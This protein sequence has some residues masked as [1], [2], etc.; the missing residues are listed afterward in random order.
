MCPVTYMYVN[1]KR[2]CLISIFFK[3]LPHVAFS[4]VRKIWTLQYYTPFFVIWSAFSICVEQRVPFLQTNFHIFFTKGTENWFERIMQSC[5][6]S[7]YFWSKECLCP[8]WSL[9]SS[10]SKS[11]PKCSECRWN[12]PEIWKW[13]QHYS[14]TGTTRYSSLNALRVSSYS[15]S[16][17]Y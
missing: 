5:W 3:A 13:S 11:S 6:S 4:R 16:F 15:R 1:W 8:S 12:M 2:D 10:N 14:G 9:L 7:F 17:M